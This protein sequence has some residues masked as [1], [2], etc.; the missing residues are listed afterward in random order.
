MSPFEILIPITAILVGGAVIIIPL[1][2][3]TARLALR[4]LVE[5]WTRLRETPLADERIRMMERRLSLVEEQVQLLE[6]ENVRLIEDAEFRLKLDG[7]EATK[8]GQR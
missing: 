2:G 5:S 1:L 7:A 8:R 4:P 6:N 3:L